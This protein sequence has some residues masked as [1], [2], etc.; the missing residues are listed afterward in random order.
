MSHWYTRTGEQVTEVEG[1]K[2]QGVRA[3]L[4]HARALNLGPG[5]T[6]IIKMADAPALNRWMVKQAVM[7]ALTLPR[8]RSESDTDFLARIER[9][10]REQGMKAAEA[11]SEIHAAFEAQCNS[12]PVPPQRQPWVDAIDRELWLQKL[13]GTRRAEVGC[14]HPRGFGTKA[15]LVVGKWLIDF[16]TKDSLEEPKDSRIWDNHSMQLGATL[17]ALGESMEDAPSRAGIMFVSRS[18]PVVCKLV[19]VDSAALQR[20]WAMFESL[21][22]FWQFQTGHAPDWGVAAAQG[23]AAEAVK[24]GDARLLD[25]IQDIFKVRRDQ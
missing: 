15:D 8:W 5:C 6:T 14:A 7:A 11:G 23:I 17:A 9:D 19:E 13:K 20:G 25:D 3:T 21:L 22:D 10:G 16:K 18:Q 2:G 24:T 4:R 12:E 1:A